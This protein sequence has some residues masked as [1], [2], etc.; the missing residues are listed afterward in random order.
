MWRRGGSA[1]SITVWRP[2]V[3][4]IG[5]IAPE[6][7]QRE[8]VASAA[9]IRRAVPDC[10]FTIYGSALF[11]EIGTVRYD[12]EI[13]AA[14]G[15]A[16]VEFPGW[17]AD[18]HD[19]LA[20]TD[21]LLVPSAGHEATT[22]VILEAHAAGVPAIAFRSGG[23]PEVVED[24]RDGW[25]VDS[26]EEMARLAVEL[27]RGSAERLAAISRQARETWERRFTLGR[28]HAELFEVLEKA[29]K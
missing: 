12:A 25:L 20:R 1:S 3:S 29:R 18:V 8:F 16:G 14:G 6:K 21:L 17:V 26:T 15:R 19:A 24:G 23:I 11:A 22:R 7:G 5:R 27:L 10:R 4:C 13:R 9:L 28:Y 2:T